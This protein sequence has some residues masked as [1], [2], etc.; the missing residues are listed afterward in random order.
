VPGARY[1]CGD[2][3]RELHIVWEN[4]SATDSLDAQRHQP[5]QGLANP[6]RR[7][8]SKA[9]AIVSLVFLLLAVFGRWP[10]GFYTLLRFAVCGSATFL[11]V[12]AFELK[13]SVWVWIMAAMAV[14]F[15]PLI[16]IRLPRDAWQVIDLIAA[17]VVAVS[18]ITIRRP[19]SQ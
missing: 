16:P 19:R 3:K 10:Y 8:I 9:P 5:E 13:K 7:H 17:V 15:N 12:Q 11:A 4:A 1:R 18:L 14:L 6:S 2:C